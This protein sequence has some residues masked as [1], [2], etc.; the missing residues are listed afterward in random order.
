MDKEQ[1]QNNGKSIDILLVEDDESDVKLTLRAFGEIDFKSNIYVVS[2]GREA[3]DFVYH[4]GEYQDN[5]KYPRPDL[6][7]MDINMPKM[8]GLEVLKELKTKPEYKVIPIIMLTSSKNDTDVLQSYD[9]GAN[10][11]IPKPIDYDEFVRI[12]EG[13]NFY[14]HVVNIFPEKS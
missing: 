8:S 4:Q 5:K 10:G 2:N 12:V 11:Y 13:F 1:R 3:L 9:C 7:L 6:I 14:W